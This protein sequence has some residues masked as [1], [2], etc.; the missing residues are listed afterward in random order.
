MLPHL[1]ELC[2]EAVD[3][4]AKMK[5]REKIY[6]KERKRDRDEFAICLGSTPE[7][8]GINRRMK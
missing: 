5:A 6:G 3:R 2:G 8:L 4:T 7:I 1:T